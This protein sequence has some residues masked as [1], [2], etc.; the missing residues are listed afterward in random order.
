[1]KNYFVLLLLLFSINIY[2]AENGYSKNIQIIAKNIDNDGNT[3]SFIFCNQ[4]S[5][6]IK[7]TRFL[8]N[9][10]SLQLNDTKT[11]IDLGV[12][13]DPPLMIELDSY[14]LIWPVENVLPIEYLRRK[15]FLN[16]FN[17]TW[18]LYS[19]THKYVS[20][21]VYFYDSRISEKF[22]PI[23]NESYVIA[24]NVDDNALSFSLII[25][26]NFE[27]DMEVDGFFN[28]KNS[29]SIKFSNGRIYTIPV[30]P[31]SQKILL[32]PGESYI[33]NINFEELL[34][35]SDNF[36]MEDFE[37]G[38]SELVWTLTLADG[39]VIT[40]NFWLIKYNNDAPFNIDG[41]RYN[42]NLTSDVFRDNLLE[43]LPPAKA[44]L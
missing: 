26:N 31:L 29:V 12:M 37:Y 28:T 6:L 20:S 2:C 15:N 42:G 16:F 22:S 3:F 40:R 9:K 8:T 23:V 11:Y 36:S 34:T 7:T 10:N 25:F 5:E 32:K 21:P 38:L 44:K 41:Y 27:A 17:M 13:K 30:N 1:M 33:E 43:S 24:K 35:N 14:Y 18:I 4:D 39:Q 19:D